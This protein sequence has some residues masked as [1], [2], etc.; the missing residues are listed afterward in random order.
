VITLY[1]ESGD[2]Q[3]A[4]ADD[5]VPRISTDSELFYRVPATGTF[6]LRVWEFQR[7]VRPGGRRRS[8]LQ[9]RRQ[10]W[11]PSCSTNLVGFTLD[12]EANDTVAHRAGGPETTT[13]S[14]PPTATTMNVTSLAGLLD[15]GNDVDV[16]AFD[17]PHRLAVAVGG[18]HS[19]RGQ[20]LRLD[21]GPRPR[22]LARLRR[23]HRPG[24]PRQPAGRALP[25]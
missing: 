24:P 6:C 11:P 25:G 3:I 12:T 22:H 21:Q 4:E 9:L 1:D 18:L 16:F 20:R 5:S 17:A 7:M 15:P 14:P 10:P 13:S 23:H 8:E 2:V 19:G